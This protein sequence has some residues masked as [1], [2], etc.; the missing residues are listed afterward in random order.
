MLKIPPKRRTGRKNYRNLYSI[1]IE[2]SSNFYTVFDF[3]QQKLF[4]AICTVYSTHTEYADVKIGR[5][6]I[7]ALSLFTPPKYPSD[8]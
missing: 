3:R 1:F 5:K 4:K 6:Q 7:S 2:A 8:R